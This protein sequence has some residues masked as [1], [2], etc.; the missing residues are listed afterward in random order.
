MDDPRTPWFGFPRQDQSLVREV[1]RVAHFDE[2]RVRQL[3]DRHPALVNASWDW[4]FGDWESPLGAASHMGRR[5]IAEYLL[6][7]GARL[8]LFAATMLGHTGSVRALVEGVGGAQRALGPH[9]ITLLAHARAGGEQAKE[10]YEYLRILGDADRGPEVKSF[11]SEEAGVYVGTYAFGPNAEDRL[12]ISVEKGQ[13][14]I[15]KAGEAGRA[16]HSR[17]EHRFFPAGVPSIEI[18]FELDGP[19]SLAIFDPELVVRVPRV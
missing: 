16:L 19:K 13:L 12:V 10:T 4:G 14:T 7:R 11:S 5:S 17:G 8:D 1:V 15:T 6:E 9:C 2:T 3:V 18:R